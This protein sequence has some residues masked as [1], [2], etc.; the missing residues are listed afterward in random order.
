[1]SR[2]PAGCQLFL[3]TFVF[4]VALIGSASS[5]ASDRDPVRV[6]LAHSSQSLHFEANGFEVTRANESLFAVKAQKRSPVQV[7]IRFVPQKNQFVLNARR[8]KQSLW[9]FELKDAFPFEIKTLKA[10]MGGK[11][12]PETL[13][14]DRVEGALEL[15]AEV[16]FADYLLGVL[17]REMP[18]AWPLDALKAQAVATRS[19]TLS[20]MR[21]RSEWSFDVEGSVLD[22]EF[23]WIPEDERGTEILKRWR[24]ALEQT[25]NEVL[26]GSSK[27]I[28]RAYYHADCGGRTTTPDF[29][30]GPTG[31]YKSVRD[32]SC[33][34]RQRNRWKLVA[35]KNWIQSQLRGEVAPSR[36]RASA[37]LE[38]S[39]IQSLFD[40]RVTL[41][42]WWDGG[43][44]DLKILSGQN[45]RQL[46]GF[47]KLRSLRF[48]TKE[49][50]QDIVFEG[51]G[52]GHG[53]GLCQWGSKDWAEQGLKY[54]AILNHY[55]PLAKL[56]RGYDSK[57]AADRKMSR[58][59]T[60]QKTQQR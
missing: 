17:N 46:L 57:L 3:S 42:E 2:L 1:M 19:Y 36:M 35:P 33:E 9:S 25:Q 11:R 30:W 59:P 58:S 21:S 4:A 45:F 16:R 49:S 51:R 24:E 53:V 60:A 54:G 7:E 5:H 14:L 18:G 43:L 20:Q 26:L 13:T 8:G 34:Q 28:F 6:R 37:G 52:F 44:S 56:S 47:S 55:Y 27:E 50:G 41:V 15:R 29:V 23:E 31:D 48:S 40:Q 32:P 22:Q 38:F 39:W 10:T 12:L